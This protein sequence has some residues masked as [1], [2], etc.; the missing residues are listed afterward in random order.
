MSH[1]IFQA[2]RLG[3]RESLAE[4]MKRYPLNVID[5]DGQNLLHEAIASN[6]DDIGEDLIVRGI[7]VNHQDRRGLT[8]LHYAAMHKKARLAK[9]ILSAGARHDIEDVHGNQP[10]WTA[11]FN[12]R[13]D[14]R[15]VEL[16][17]AHGSSPKHRNHHGKSAVDFAA[18]IEDRGLLTTLLGN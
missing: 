9:R 4:L 12:A 18:Q 7:N 1:E 11:T 8:P 5:E 16:L 14:Y 2:V 13:G 17:V 6:Q 15:I 10:L 3:D